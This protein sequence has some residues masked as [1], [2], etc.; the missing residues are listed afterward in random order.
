M[1][2]SAFF[3][4]RHGDL[5][6]PQERDDENA[7]RKKG[8]GLDPAKM[9]MERER[10]AP[11]QPIGWC[12]VQLDENYNWWVEKTDRPS[13]NSDEERLSILDP[14]QVEYV[15]DLLESLRE[16]G[17]QG[18][19]VLRAFLPFSIEKDLGGGRVRLR[20]TEEELG[21]SEE[22]LFALPNTFGEAG[23]YAEFLDHISLLRAKLLND[24]YSFVQRLTVTELEEGVREN[25]ELE[26]QPALH[27]FQE[28][29]GILEYSPMGFEPEKEEEDA[30]NLTK[31]VE[32]E[33]TA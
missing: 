7:L 6:R 20:I 8:I 21:K 1:L 13:D 31:G 18:D 24:T 30:E 29:A 25:C 12:V 9:A 15:F 2:S 23:H 17:L 14:K 26:G 11:N 19:V 3:F 16:Y 33:W 22:K 5:R 28:I 32:E 27:V 10:R 4:I